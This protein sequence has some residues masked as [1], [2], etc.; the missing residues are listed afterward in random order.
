MLALWVRYTHAPCEHLALSLYPVGE[1]PTAERDL[2]RSHSQ[3]GWT[4]FEPRF[5]QLTYYTFNHYPNLPL[6]EALLCVWDRGTRVP[7]PRPPSPHHS[8]P[9]EVGHP[10]SGLWDGL[11]EKQEGTALGEFSHSCEI[12]HERSSSSLCIAFWQLPTA[13]ALSPNCAGSKGGLRFHPSPAQP[14]A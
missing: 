12:N 11:K 6:Q 13:K 10:G 2:Q 14:L 9:L 8:G 7:P 4:G 3:W 5:V 1:D